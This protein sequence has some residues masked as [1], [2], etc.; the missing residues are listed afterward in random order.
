[1][2]NIFRNSSGSV[3]AYERDSV[4]TWAEIQ[5][6]VASD[7]GFFHF[8][9]TAVD[10]SVDCAIIGAPFNDKNPQVDDNAGKS[11]IFHG[12]CLENLIVA[13]DSVPSRLFVADSTMVTLDSVNIFSG[14]STVFQAGTSITLTTG[15]RA[16]CGSDFRAFIEAC[17]P[18]PFTAPISSETI[19][20][21]KRKTIQ[22]SSLQVFPNPNNGLM[23]IQF[24]IEEEKSTRVDLFHSS[25]KLIKT[26]FSGKNIGAYN[27]EVN[28]NLP[29]GIYFVRLTNNDKQ[30]IQKVIV[31]QN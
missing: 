10:V 24:N 7:R 9:G 27:L 13:L 20:E 5:K 4:G 30:E 19:F 16:H 12:E 14:D 3:Y 31:L 26:I 25:G 8:F 2:G 17:M 22:P 28:E 6:L 1:M 18:L 11:Y 29:A 23:S 15:F 21:E